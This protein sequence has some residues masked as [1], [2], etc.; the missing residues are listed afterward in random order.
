MN[1]RPLAWTPER[2]RGAPGAAC[3]SWPIKPGALKGWPLTA[4]MLSPGWIPAA[5]AGELGATLKTLPGS[6]LSWVSSKPVIRSIATRKFAAGPPAR[7]VIRCH[8]G[9]EWNPL[10]ASKSPASMP[11]MRTYPRMGSALS[12]YRVP[13]LVNDQ[14]LVPAPTEN[15]MTRTLVASLVGGDQE[16]EHA[17]NPDHVQKRCHQPAHFALNLPNFS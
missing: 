17:P 12:A 7:I 11:P 9:L 2:V 4:R 16:Q 13:P 15:S 10:G 5:S 14:S 8:A 1:G 6:V 3:S